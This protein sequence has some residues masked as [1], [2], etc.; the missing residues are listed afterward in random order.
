MDDSRDKSPSIVIDC[1]PGR[2]SG[3]VT[4]TARLNSDVLHTDKLDIQRATSRD[5][6]LSRLADQYPEL[7]TPE[8]RMALDA[9]LL[10]QASS[11]NATLSEGMIGA[12]ADAQAIVADFIAGGDG[13]SG[14][15]R[16]EIDTSRIVRPELFH[17][18]DV[19]GVAVPV[20][21]IACGKP[22]G[23]W[24]HYLRWHGDGR[25]ERRDIEPAI[26]LSDGRRLWVYPTPGEPELTT[27][28][29]W[30]PEAR[31][32]WLD[33]ADS[34]EPVRLL[35]SV[36][37]RFACF[38]DFPADGAEGTT[39]TL[40][41]WVVLTYT[42]SAWGSVPYLYVGGPASSGKST[43]FRVLSRLVFRPLE[44][45]NMTAPCLFRTLHECGGVLLLDEAERLR[46]GT[47]EAGELR[48]IL[49]SG[50]KVGSPAIRLEKIGDGFKRTAFQCFGPKAL[51]SIA[52]L[53]EALASRCIRVGMF[54][55]AAD[56]PKPRRRLDERPELWAEL[57]DGLHALALEHGPT[58]LA[59][60]N[61]A[62]C[63]P[64]SLNGRD[65][66]LWQPLF[67]LAS[68]FEERGA[69]GLV[70]VL[71]THAE[72][73]IETNRDDAVPEA[74]ELLLRLLAEHVGD[75]TSRTLKAGDLLKQAR[76]A[77][78]VTFKLWSPKGVG[79]ALA[80]YGLRTRK[81]SGNVGR[82]YSGVTVADLRRVQR[83][84]GFDVPL[85]AERVAQGA[86]G[87]PR[88]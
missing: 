5:R 83:A 44:S 9:E 63:C 4:L 13:S 70:S 32:A 21:R 38:L 49:L 45:S 82:T 42:Y 12:L 8:Q 46:D 61:R 3:V 25:R 6:F 75:G 71:R 19:S 59:L 87:D 62:D 15:T 54:R 17:A 18:S 86:G 11:I 57:R 29:G 84:Y 47:P 52:S 53:P 14:V 2:G 1:K 41:L 31:A 36:C 35:Q 64:P 48:S 80:R 65:F 50:Y 40:A 16:A 72:R 7:L 78:P 24:Q 26:D 37:E 88:S 20:N 22:I 77:D 58:W 56:S 10:R 67:G 74:D 39:A 23:R 28:A 79:N 85:P 30:S 69:D 55:A 73:T 51:A 43:A 33:G 68:W 60:A 34:P 81:G 27:R 76:E 66:E